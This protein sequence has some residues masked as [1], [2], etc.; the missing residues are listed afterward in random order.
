DLV[1]VT[2]ALARE[3]TE[4][5]GLDVDPADALTDGRAMDR[6]RAIVAAQ[7]G[8][9]DAPLP[10]AAENEVLT[11]GGDGIVQRLDAMAVGVA[12]WRLGA[13]RARKEDDVSATAGVI[14]HAKVGDRVRAGDPVL[15]LRADDPSRF[16]A[17]REALTDAWTL[18]ADPADSGPLILDRITPD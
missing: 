12:A 17:A 10:V 8:D 7:G 6:W 11:A 16:A 15:E 5:A 3:M 14:C 9:P 2:L 13:G 4:L 1:E 18:G